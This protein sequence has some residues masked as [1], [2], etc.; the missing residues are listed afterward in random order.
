MVYLTYHL[1]GQVLKCIVYLILPC[2]AKPAKVLWFVIVSLGFLGAGFLIGESYNEWQKNPIST[3]IT[4]KP[5][6]DLDFPVV[7]VCPPKDSNTALYH[8][9]VKAGNGTLSEKDTRLLKKAAYNIFLKKPHNDYVKG[10]LTNLHMGR[11][12]QFLQGFYS[13]PMP[14]N[15]DNALQV[16]AH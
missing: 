6:A 10:M 13:L 4:T 12:D 1:P 9:L 11:I 2:Q 3:S 14:Y 5:I 8:D 7:T 15:S 16:K